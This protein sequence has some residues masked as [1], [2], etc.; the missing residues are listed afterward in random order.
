MCRRA[1]TG[2]SN[3]SC[4]GMRSQKKDKEVLGGKIR[5]ERFGKQFKNLLPF[6]QPSAAQSQVQGHWGVWFRFGIQKFQPAIQ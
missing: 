4:R 2:Q 6:I 3:H 1:R 5:A